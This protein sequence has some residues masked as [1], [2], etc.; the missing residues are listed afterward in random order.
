[1]QAAAFVGRED[2][3]VANSNES[4]SARTCQSLPGDPIAEIARRAAQTNIVIINEAHDSPQ[5]RQFIAEVLNALWP[6]GYKT[7]AAET[8]SA[9]MELAGD[10]ARL[11]DGF[12]SAEP[13]F[14]RIL[15]A[16]KRKGYRFVAYEQTP[17]QSKSAAAPGIDLRKVVT[18]REEVQTENLMHALFLGAPDTKVIIHV[19]C[20]HV[21]ERSKEGQVKWM[22]ERLTEATGRDPLTISQTDCL[23]ASTATTLAQDAASAM[24][25]Y[26]AH[27][28]LNL[29]DQRPA[30]RQAIGDIPIPVPPDLSANS[31]PVVIEATP[32]DAP[33]DAV[34]VDR[35]LVRPGESIPLLLPPG[36]YRVESV[37][38]E[39]QH[40]RSSD[41]LT[42]PDRKP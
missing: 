26:I 42:V 16:A 5:H 39:G 12:Y 9:D 38:S 32:V 28:A 11:G 30:W 40:F 3:F 18:R 25:L 19:G 29:K 14:G 13:I 10:W 27:P 37:T 24:D 31:E 7:Y 4:F 2:F 41:T 23:S 6:L 22:A 34:P 15:T 17:E 21:Q 33:I 1:M 36:H 20:Q 35:V 8:F